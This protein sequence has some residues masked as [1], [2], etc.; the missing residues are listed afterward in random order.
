MALMSLMIFLNVGCSHSNKAVFADDP[1]KLSGT[2]IGFSNAITSR[3]QTNTSKTVR[4]VVSES[5]GIN[6]TAQW[7]KISGP[8][9]HHEG[10]HANEST[11]TLVGSLNK[12]DGVFFLVETDENGFWYCRTMNKDLI[13]AHLIQSGPEHVSTFVAFTRS[14]SSE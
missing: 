10:D 9:G 8:G 5:G 6:G 2:W 13:H 4:L 12:E 14:D 7:T 1:T 11:E 3:G